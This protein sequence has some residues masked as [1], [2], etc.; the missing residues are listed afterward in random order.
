MKDEEVTRKE[1]KIIFGQVQTIILFAWAG[2]A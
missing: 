1:K 2:L